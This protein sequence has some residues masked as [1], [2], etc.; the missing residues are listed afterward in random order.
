[1]GLERVRAVWEQMGKPQAPINIAVG[2]TNGKGSTGAMLE[3]ILVAAG[4]NTGF[5]TSPHLLRFNERVRIGKKSARDAE[6]ILAFA[7][8]E[9]ARRSLQSPVP[10]TYFEYVTLAGFWMLAQAQLDVAIL[11]VGMG[12]RLDAVNIVDADA[13]VVVSIDLDHQSFL[14]DTIEKIG[15]EKA[16]IYRP[17]RPAVFGDLNP[18]ATLTAHAAQTGADLWLLSRDFRYRRMD[19][20]WQFLGRDAARH[21]LPFPSLRGAYQ[22]KNA[23]AAL[24][25][26]ESLRDKL[27]V[28][29]GHIKRGL[30]E[31][32]WPGRMQVLPG[33]PTVVL[34]VAHNPHAARALQ[35]A[36]GSMGFYE[37]TYAVFSMLKDKDI[38]QVIEIMKDRID[39]WCVAGLEK[40]A[41]GRAT[42]SEALAQMLA[43]HGAAGRFSQHVDIAGAFAAARARAGQ[44]DRIL[45][46]GSFHTVADV[47]STIG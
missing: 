6:F 33:R 1:M 39:Y 35:D 42:S 19:G 23:S 22:L 36:L 4:F 25:V 5:Y 31:V 43:L 30:V 46:F 26:L 21:A 41:G 11:E 38:D 47:L 3:S 40:T 12:G 13:S 7:A 15:L 20:Q 28:S 8:V 16:H 10:L 37:N 14:G 32:E 9:Q 34:D 45:V 29:Q 2:G 17:G 44:N 18:P 27:P 24:A